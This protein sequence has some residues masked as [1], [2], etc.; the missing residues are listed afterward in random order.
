MIFI[1]AK[2]EDEEEEDE[3][4]EYEEY[5]EDSL[6]SDAVNT[7]LEALGRMQ[8]MVEEQQRIPV[9]SYSYAH[10]AYPAV[11]EVQNA[12]LITL[13]MIVTVVCL[14]MQQ[15]VIYCHCLANL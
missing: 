10:P 5:D 11:L 1:C 7:M 15:S 6:D 14:L 8:T 3:Y 9:T 4:D 13:F 2:K 12:Q